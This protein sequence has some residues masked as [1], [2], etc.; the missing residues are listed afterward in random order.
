MQRTGKHRQGEES[1]FRLNFDDERESGDED[2]SLRWISLLEE[3]VGGRSR[4]E[5]EES[6]VEKRFLWQGSGANT[7]SEDARTTT[8]KESF[9]LWILHPSIFQ[10]LISF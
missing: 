2:E 3:E 10:A 4:G 5:R 6:G 9:G 7:D 8:G 1:E